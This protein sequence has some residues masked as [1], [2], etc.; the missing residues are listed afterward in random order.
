MK[1][2][3]NGL[4][5]ARLESEIGAI[6]SAIAEFEKREGYVLGLNSFN[7]AARHAELME[8]YK[9]NYAAVGLTA[10]EDSVFAEYD[11]AHDRKVALAN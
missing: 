2:C 11:A 6:N 7:K 5:D 9:E 4:M 8:R 3:V 1:N 10:P